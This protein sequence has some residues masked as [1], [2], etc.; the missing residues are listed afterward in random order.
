MGQAPRRGPDALRAVRG[1]LAGRGSGS[2]SPMICSSVLT[3]AADSGICLRR[4][5]HEG[6][7][8]QSV[9]TRRWH[10]GQTWSA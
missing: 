2:G 8:D 10:S 9:S 7:N 6:Q 3:G 4:A 1:V 5:P